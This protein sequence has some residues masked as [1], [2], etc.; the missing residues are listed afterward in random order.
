MSF[1]PLNNGESFF[2]GEDAK[3]AIYDLLV[4]KT[5]EL[6]HKMSFKEACDDPEMVYP[7]QYAYY[8][9]SF[10]KA[11]E[12]AWREAQDGTEDNDDDDDECI[13]KISSAK[14]EE[15]KIRQE[16]GQKKDKPRERPPRFLSWPKRRTEVGNNKASTPRKSPDDLNPLRVKYGKEKAIEI[17]SEFYQEHDRMPTV[18]EC[19]LRVHGLPS[20]ETLRQ[21][22]GTRKEWLIEVKKNIALSSDE[23]K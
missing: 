15:M 18:A 6:G 11:A 8:F 16:K 2:V 21:Y 1:L 19:R 5:R 22:F 13:V 20:D 14:L 10:G 17:L 3:T 23:E 9:G 7:N 12:M 4:E